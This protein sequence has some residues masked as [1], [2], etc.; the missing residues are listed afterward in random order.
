MQE[1][2]QA[3]LEIGTI[4]AM[5]YPAVRLG[6]G[7]ILE[8][9]RKLAEDPFWTAIEVGE[10]LDDATRREL[11]AMLRVAGMT[12]VY[13]AALPILIRKIGIAATDEEER[14]AA[15]ATLSRHVDHAYELGARMMMVCSGRD[16]GESLRAAATD[17]YIRSLG[18]LC[19]DA[20]RKATAYE[21]GIT[22]ENFDHLVEKKFLVGPTAMAVEVV[23]AVRAAGHDNIGL[24]VD[25]SHLPLLDETPLHALGTAG[26]Y[27]LHAHIGN[28]I[29]RYPDHPLFGDNHPRFGIAEGENGVPEVAEFVRRLRAQGFF[30][31]KVP[32]GRPVLTIEVKPM[33]GED[34]DLVLANAKRV[35]QQAWALA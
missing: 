2:W 4:Q 24:T 27:L 26:D 3:F 18:E 25:L 20:R 21:M 5:A 10:V 16:P 7:P 30:A 6:D 13:C 31:R 22:F 17:A 12:V 29:L 35:W 15:V 19:A 1:P 9:A 32:T 14:R 8:T 23:R 11:A 33:P 28:C 34:G